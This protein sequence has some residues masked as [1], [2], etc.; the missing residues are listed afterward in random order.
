M[1]QVGG[2]LG[3]ALLS[4]LAVSA[5]TTALAGAHRTPE[6]VAQASV[7]GYTT[8]FWCSAALLAAGALASA[9]LLRASDQSDAQSQPTTDDATAA[10]PVPAH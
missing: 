3:T 6:L 5:T 10:Q 8:A 7:H 2:S 1:Q 4:T 9:L